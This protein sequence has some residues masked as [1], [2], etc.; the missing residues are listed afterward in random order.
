M[1]LHLDSGDQTVHVLNN[2]F[3]SMSGGELPTEPRRKAQA[4]WNV[5]LIE[6][7]LARDPAFHIVVLGDLN[8][9][10][11]SPPLD[12][13]RAG[14]L[15][16]VYEYVAPLRPYS[17]IY[18]GESETLDHILMTPGLYDHLV[19]VEAVHINADY[20]LAEPGDPSA[21][22][23]SDHDPIVAVFSFY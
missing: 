15:Q 6:P 8:S 11:E 2:H 14:G 10:Y 23:T 18:E 17:Y 22:G 4:Q 3:T 7:I 19:Q 9:F 16:H 20:T 13:L 12:I 21:S 5:S 1:T